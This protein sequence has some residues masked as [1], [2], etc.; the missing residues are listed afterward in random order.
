M[1]TKRVC[2]EGNRSNWSRWLLVV[3]IWSATAWGATQVCAAGP[4]L[5]W[6]LRALKSPSAATRKSAC[7]WVT[8]HPDKSAVAPLITALGDADPGVR[9]TAVQ[10]LGAIKDLR[11]TEPLIAAFNDANQTVCTATKAVLTSY[12]AEAVPA[13]VAALKDPAPAVRGGAAEVLGTLKDA[14]AVEPLIAASRDANQGVSAAAKTAVAAHGSG[15]VDALVVALRDTDAGTRRDA[16]ELLGALKDPR[17]VEPLIAALKDADQGVRAAA[18]T[19]LASYGPAA[20]NALTVA[21]KDPDPAVSE[22][23]SEILGVP[24]PVAKAKSL[25]EKASAAIPTVVRALLPT[26]TGGVSKVILEQTDDGQIRVTALPLYGFMAMADGR[27][28]LWSVGSQ[29]CL[30]TPRVVL[31]GYTFERDPNDDDLL[32][33][34][35]TPAGY[36]CVHGKG[37]ITDP[38]GH[39]VVATSGGDAAQALVAIDAA[40]AEYPLGEAYLLRGRGLEKLGRGK[41]ARASYARAV[42]LLTKSDPVLCVEARNALLLAPSTLKGHTNWVSSVAFSPD[43]KLLASGSKDASVKLWS[44]P[45]EKLQATLEGHTDKVNSVAFSPDG[46]LLA[47]GSGRFEGADNTV[48]LWSMP[49]GKLQATLEGHTYVVTSVA[50]SPDGKLLASGSWDNTVKLWSLPEGKLQATLEGH[51]ESI[52]SVAFSPDGKLLASGSGRFEGADNTVKLWSLPEGKL[53]ATLEGHDCGVDSVAF[54]PDGKLLASG[55]GATVRLWSLPEGKL[56][57][58]LEGLD[59]VTSV[60]FSPDGKLLASGSIDKTVKLWSLPEGK[61]EATLEGHTQEV[62]SVAFSPDGKLLASGSEDETVFLW[63]VPEGKPQAADAVPAGK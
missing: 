3:L 38:D 35:V 1:M 48:K 46:K 4:D 57:A 42:E 5:G 24:S 15:A 52:R 47:S 6:A 59:S 25:L 27:P 49:E 44:L 16:V 13:L 56:Q 18:K 40:L 34:D 45:E 12:G 32:V 62:L 10:A 50:F 11:A 39:R 58:T 8:T 7:V 54:S 63:P 60:A 37:V 21:L 43:G 33:F 36:R 20:V 23:A 51:T 26:E 14:R 9:E 30:L 41:E 17:A 22:S 61:L 55:A 19:A 53:Q 31:R 29:H 2:C 28:I